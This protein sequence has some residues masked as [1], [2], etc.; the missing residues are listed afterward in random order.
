V[1][2]EGDTNVTV[3][4]MATSD[5]TA[6]T[7]PAGGVFPSTATADENVTV[8][9]PRVILGHPTFRAPE[10][11]SID[12]ATSMV[13]WAL[14]QAQNV[15]HQESGGIIDEQRRLLL[16]ASML[17]ERITV[18]RVRVEARQHHLDVRGELLNRLQTNI[19]NRDSQKM[20]AEAKELYASAKAQ[21]NGTIKQTEEL[22]VCVQAVEGRE[23]AV[24]ELEQK[25]QEREA[26]DN[27]MLERELVGLAT[28]ES[29]LESREAALAA[30]QKDF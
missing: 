10:D 28:Y 25:L 1:L 21:A 9:E 24:D 3:E 16:W 29:S 19:N 8:E 15:L 2:P 6:S 30:E 18:E 13:H 27:L 11:V 14:T 7:G 20:L 26:L 22:A 12:E 5:P 4:E 23:Q 17:K